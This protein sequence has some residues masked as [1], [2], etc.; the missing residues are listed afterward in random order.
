MNIKT[1]GLDIAKN[2]FQ[3]H[4][5]NASGKVEL[6]KKLKRS[7]VLAF[8][9]NQ[10]QCL[11]GLEACAGSHYWARELLN[12]GHE[13]KLIPAQYVKP[14]V[15]GNK[16]DGNDAE[17]ICEAVQRPNMRFVTVNTQPQ[18]DLQML[19]RI[20]SRLVGD[21][22]ALIN[23]IRGLLGEYGVVFARGPSQVR[24]G[25]SQLLKQENPEFSAL[26]LDL[27]T[28]LK[29]QLTALDERIEACDQK[30]QRQCQQDEKSQKLDQIPGIGA[31]IATAF[32]A[33]INDG[34]QFKNGRQLAA[35]LGLTPKEHSS[36]GKQKLLG[37][38]KR[39][40]P[41]LRQL[42]I[43]GARSVLTHA[44]NKTDRLSRWARE[45]K[46]RR[47]FNVAAVALANKLA[48][49]VWAVLAQA[50]TYDENWQDQPASKAPVANASGL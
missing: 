18:Q 30:V 9:A 46:A 12:L 27:L 20:R 4:G 47:G 28:D 15:K 37:I 35:N 34:K 5:T 45:V 43:H 2:V 40:N 10:P 31:L 41:Y 39:G 14:Y 7:Q 3:A 33:A 24:N 48:R 42:L 17:A 11:I 29:Q 23:Q 1:I 19:H 6:R 36:G 21:R 44:D 25:L 26:A 38:S 49:I 50:R 13:V 32:I 22:T 8:F 16:T